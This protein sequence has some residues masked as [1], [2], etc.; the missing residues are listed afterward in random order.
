ME[1]KTPGPS[2]LSRRPV[3]VGHLPVVSGWPALGIPTDSFLGEDGGFCLPAT[4][5]GLSTSGGGLAAGMNPLLSRPAQ[6]ERCRRVTTQ[7]PPGFCPVHLPLCGF[8][9]SLR[10][11]AIFVLP[12]HSSHI[13]LRTVTLRKK[14]KVYNNQHSVVLVKKYTHR[15][16]MG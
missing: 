15:V 8:T 9:P 13:C 16:E 5:W 3:G 2:F 4:R 12:L 11:G 14:K 7:C 1:Y 10:P 6:A